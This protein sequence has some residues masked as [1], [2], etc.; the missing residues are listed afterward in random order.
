MSVLV[1]VDAAEAVEL[2]HHGEPDGQDLAHNRRLRE[3]G[4]R[5]ESTDP[6]AS[7]LVREDLQRGFVVLLLERHESTIRD[8]ELRKTSPRQYGF[9]HERDA[10]GLQAATRRLVRA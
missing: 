3:A 7:D 2:F 1:G 10:R 9:L 6:R 8:G 4:V 5:L